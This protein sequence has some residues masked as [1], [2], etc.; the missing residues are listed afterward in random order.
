[1]KK[2]G[3]ASPYD[4]QPAHMRDYVSLP[5]DEDHDEGGV[6]INSGIGNH[7]FYLAAD[8]IGGKAWEKTGLIWYKTL[9]SGLPTDCSYEIFAS[10]TVQVAGDLFGLGNNEQEA[11]REAWDGVGIQVRDLSVKEIAKMKK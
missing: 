3:S 10:H 5:N 2:P 1:M 9:S 11:I 6:H 8:K 7:A 4:K